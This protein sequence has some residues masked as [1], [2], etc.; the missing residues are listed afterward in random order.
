MFLIT[1]SFAQ[2]GFKWAKIHGDDI[3]NFPERA[4]FIDSD[5]AGNIYVGGQV[6]DLFVRDSNGQTISSQANPSVDS[7]YNYGG[8]DAWIA[9][10]TP[11][12]ILRWHRYAGSGSNDEYYSMAV[13]GNG[14]SYVAGHI[15]NNPH[16]VPKSFDGIN[17]PPNQFGTFIAKVNSN[18]NLIWHTSFGG[19]TVNNNF[20]QYSAAIREVI[21]NSNNT[22]SCF[23]I[24]GGSNAFGFQKLY[25]RDSLELGL[26]E[27]IFD[28]NGNYIRVKT[29]PFPKYQGLPNFTSIK[30]KDNR[31]LMTGIVEQDSV[32][33]G[34][35]TIIKSGF[36]N[37][38][39]I[40]FDT[41]MNKLWHF[42]S[43]NAFDQFQDSK[44]IGDSLIVSGHFDLAV[45]NTVQFDT[46][47]YTGSSN[48]NQA[49][50]LFVFDINTGKLLALKPSRSQG[51]ATRVRVGGVAASKD[52]LAI[53]GLFPGRITF[54]NTTNYLQAVDNCISCTN[55]D[56]YFA[57]FNRNGSFFM[58]DVIYSSGNSGENVSAMHIVDST[59]YLAGLIGDSVILPGVDTL[60]VRSSNDA[61]IAAYRISFT[62]SIKE[63]SGFIKADNGILAYPNPTEGIVNLMGEAIGSIGYLYNISGQQVKEYRLQPKSFNQSIDLSGLKTGIYFLI[64]PGRDGAQQL[65]LIKQ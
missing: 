32:F 51:F 3:S 56:L 11:D 59:I 29:Y 53:G 31:V 39:S 19:D 23:F 38:I 33:V 15:Y 58:E 25:D 36:N 60:L 62:T 35:D 49:G 9:S 2:Q 54:S 5:D 30:V 63:N 61:F 6:N 50:G 41:S 1:L 46:I 55:S 24:G 18:G 10:Y 28:L 40:C 4:V 12:G 27:A 52:F 16:R 47:T 13:A 8:K 21:I 7:L 34:N 44:I 48:N 17:L 64:I 22:I 42:Y 45:S 65:K 14:D 37:S 20:I 57:V 43:S 26:H